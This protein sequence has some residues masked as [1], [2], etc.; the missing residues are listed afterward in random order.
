MD[1]FLVHVDTV[2]IVIGVSLVEILICHR[3]NRL[4]LEQ[5]PKKYIRNSV[6]IIGLGKF[7][8]LGEN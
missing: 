1:I 7:L 2:H 4:I 8:R 6:K 5:I 3:T